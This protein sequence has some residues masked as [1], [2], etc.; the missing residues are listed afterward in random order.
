VEQTTRTENKDNPSCKETTQTAC[1]NVTLR[2]TDGGPTQTDVDSK[3]A[4]DQTCHPNN[5]NSMTDCVESGDVKAVNGF[6]TDFSSTPLMQETSDA[7]SVNRLTDAE[8]VET[9]RIN[10][11]PYDSGASLNYARSPVVLRRHRVSRPRPRPRHRLSR[12]RHYMLTFVLIS[13]PTTLSWLLTP[14]REP[15]LRL[16]PA[17]PLFTAGSHAAGLRRIYFNSLLKLI[18]VNVVR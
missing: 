11:Y 17:R 9:D 4:R 5:V 15:P 14:C 7:I 8:T 6:S 13:P 18:V 12:P 10:A 16:L 3:H 1:N 2:S